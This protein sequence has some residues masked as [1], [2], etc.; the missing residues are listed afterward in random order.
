MWKKLERAHARN[1]EGNCIS[2]LK[3]KFHR[4]QWD[5]VE[6]CRNH[7]TTVQPNITKKFWGRSF[8]KSNSEKRT[9]WIH[10]N[11][12]QLNWCEKLS[13]A[14][15]QCVYYIG[16]MCR[17]CCCFCCFSVVSVAIY[18]TDW[19]VVFTSLVSAVCH[20]FNWTCLQE[21]HWLCA[22]FSK[23]PCEIYTKFF[24]YCIYLRVASS[25]W[26]NAYNF[27]LCY[28]CAYIHWNGVTLRYFT[29]VWREITLNVYSF[30]HI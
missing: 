12:T 9:C 15:V 10:E 2:K 29:F 11:Y 19:H 30:Q 6:S 28:K 25:E 17:W 3:T 24:D 22:M 20:H 27:Q 7:K 23:M 18:T 8:E 13:K 1:E 21:T 5:D 4:K 26:I 14:S 16:F